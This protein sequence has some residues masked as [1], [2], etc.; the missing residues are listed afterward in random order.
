MKKIALLFALLLG[1]YHL[2][3]TT[4]SGILKNSGAAVPN[5]T[6]TLTLAN[7]T[8]PSM[9]TGRGTPTVVYALTADNTGTLPSLAVTGNDQIRCGAAINHTYYVATLRNSSGVILWTNSY[10]IDGTTWVADTASILTDIPPVD[11]S[12]VPVATPD[13]PPSNPTAWDDEFTAATLDPKWTWTN[14]TDATAVLTAGALV[15]T[16]SST[17][18]SF[19]ILTESAPTGTWTIEAKISMQG[20]EQLQDYDSFNLVVMDS[21]TGHR[22]G[23][24]VFAKSSN[25]GG[26]MEVQEYSNLTDYFNDAYAYYYGLPVGHYYFRIAKDSANLTYSFSYDGSAYS[27]VLVEP[28]STFVANPNLIGFQTWS[29]YSGSPINLFNGIVEWIRRVN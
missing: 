22:A 27:T 4:V 5:G 3:A 11:N 10:Q 14:Q 9:V 25:L 1:S 24:G 20:I 19:S 16:S 23:F 6:L 2:Q 21:A 7:C 29:T 8:N 12:Y 17:A 28:M 15:M 18:N 13:S 26:G